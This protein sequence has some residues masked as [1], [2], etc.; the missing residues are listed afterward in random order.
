M[1]VKFDPIPEKKWLR[2]FVQ[3]EVD[4]YLKGTGTHN[5]SHENT[6]KMMPIDRLGDPIQGSNG[7]FFDKISSGGPKFRK[8]VG[9]F[10][11]Y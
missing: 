2:C 6:L 3:I 5:A 7:T 9:R 1:F 10:L 11:L 4:H 8:L